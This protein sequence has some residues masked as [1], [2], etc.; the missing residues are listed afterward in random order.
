MW[1]CFKI[2]EVSALSAGNRR[3]LAFTGP[4]AIEL[5]QETFNTVKH[6]SQE[7]KVKP[8]E[9]IATVEK[10]QEEL[11]QLQ[12]KLNKLK[13]EAWINQIPTWLDKVENINN[14][15]FLFLLLKDYENSELKEIATIL[16]SKKPGI[17]F[18]ASNNGTS[19]FI[20]TISPQFKDK[21]NT[22]E[23]SSFLKKEANLTG[24]GKDNIQGGGPKI[25]SDLEAKIKNWIKTI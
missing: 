13:K 20:C 1:R 8:Q 3:I 24:G 4:K 21:L 14:I 5:F 22:K 19:S 9:V 6:L 12:S 2:V 16:L 15:P 11:K 18:I 23:F 17:Y 25:E 7:F 10:Q